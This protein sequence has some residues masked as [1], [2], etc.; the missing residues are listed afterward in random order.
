MCLLAAASGGSVPSLARSGIVVEARA[1]AVSPTLELPGEVRSTQGSNVISHY[2]YWVGINWLAPEG[3]HI[4]KGQTAAVVN[5]EN[6]ADRT[7]NASYW[8][9]ET[10]ATAA[11]KAAANGLGEAQRVLTV[12]RA[13]WDLE[14]AKLE[15]A[16]LEAGP[17]EQKLQAAELDVKGAA[18]EQAGAEA[19]LQRLKSLDAGA[20]VSREKL[21]EAEHAVDI[22]RIRQSEAQNAVDALRQGPARADLL[23]AQA[24]VSQAQAALRAAEDSA[25]ADR[26]TDAAALA[27]ARAQVE[28]VRSKWKE[29]DDSSRAMKRVAGASGTVLWPTVDPGGRSRPGLASLWATP[30]L[31]II[32]PRQAVFVARATEEQVPRLKVGM[33]AQVRLE[34]GATGPVA[35]RIAAIAATSQDLI[36]WYPVGETELGARTGVRMYEVVIAFDG[37]DGPDFYQGMA[38]RAEV[39]VGPQEQRTLVPRACVQD[40]A[41][42]SWVSVETAAG[43]APRQV[44]LGGSDGAFVE[45]VKGLRPGE[46]VALLAQ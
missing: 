44:V 42:G 43:W 21:V 32:D 41:G 19:A 10:E 36:R 40:S 15:L 30:I 39:G 7:A 22:A 34:G 46:K 24:K 20:G 45:V 3:S 16:A 11:E 13:E 17:G 12:H 1:A 6:M 28:W 25:A 29:L 14:E 37:R 9:E 2:G 23:A 8:L 5:N 35:G 26:Q 38:G 4:E 27:R 18:L 33:E 31:T